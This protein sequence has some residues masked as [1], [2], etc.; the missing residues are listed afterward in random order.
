MA[1]DDDFPDL[2]EGASA[3][4]SKEGWTAIRTFLF[5]NVDA[6]DPSGTV[7][8]LI[9]SDRVPQRGDPHPSLDIQADDISG[10]AKSPTQVSITVTYKLLSAITREPDDS[11]PGLIS[12]GSSVQETEVST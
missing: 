6:S 1:E 9:Q 12:V 7:S 8:N 5:N 2:V 4:Y 3:K 11:K 10:E